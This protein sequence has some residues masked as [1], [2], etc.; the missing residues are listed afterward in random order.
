MVTTFI[1]LLAAGETRL[2]IGLEATAR[3]RENAALTQSDIETALISY[4]NISNQNINQAIRISDITALLDGLTK[5]DFL[6]VTDISTIPYARPK[7]HL[8]PL[9]WSRKTNVGST[10]I[11][12]WTIQWQGAGF[13]RIIKDSVNLGFAQSNIAFTDPDNT[14]TITLQTSG[15]TIGNEWTFKTYPFLQDINLDDFTVPVVELG[16]LNITV[17]EQLNPQI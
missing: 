5:V 6:T 9:V 14:L 4:G 13:F 16:D 10:G 7:N 12:D 2:Y 1:N 11:S 17:I 8:N 15:Y 3:F